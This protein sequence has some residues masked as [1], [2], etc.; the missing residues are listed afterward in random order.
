MLSITYK[1]CGVV[2]LL[3]NFLSGGEREQN[4]KVRSMAGAFAL[5]I[6]SLNLLAAHE[7]LS[8]FPSQFHILEI[9][10]MRMAACVDR[11]LSTSALSE[12]SPLCHW[13]P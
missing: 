7:Q 13:L 2:R 10:V 9:T 11:E 5:L 12:L 8:S 3:L 1:I 4:M 6:C